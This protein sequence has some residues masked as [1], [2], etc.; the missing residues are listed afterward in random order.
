MLNF[1]YRYGSHLRHL[2][3]VEVTS[4]KLPG[5]SLVGF[6][7]LRRVLTFTVETFQTVSQM[8]MSVRLIVMV[9]QIRMIGV[10]MVI[11]CQA[12]MIII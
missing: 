2:S 8:V 12:V 1:V 4:P 7:F 3:E 10:R 5:I 11:V 9:V 6:F